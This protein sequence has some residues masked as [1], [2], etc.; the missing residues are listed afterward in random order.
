M[1]FLAIDAILILCENVTSGLVVYPKVIHQR[2]QQEL[3]FMATENI[4]MAATAQGG[5]RQELHE[6][7]RQHS[8][9][10]GLA[11]KRDGKP[12]D[13][14]ERI[15]GDPVFAGVDLTSVLDT[16]RFVGTSPFQVDV[17]V[18]ECIEPIR[19]KYPEARQLR[20]QVRV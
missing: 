18:R 3:P 19:K 15:A 16:T 2:L 17:F 9:A 12:N 4:L 7:I 13:L 20:D 5:D 6:R 10:A 14:L 11:V 1:T 8:N